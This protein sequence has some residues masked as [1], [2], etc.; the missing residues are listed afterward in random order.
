VKI[1]VKIGR[2]RQSEAQVEYQRQV[3]AAGGVYVIAKTFDGF[4]TW[5]DEF[6]K[7]E[8]ASHGK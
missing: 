8:E 7:V 5:Y 3:E 4:L 6:V 1:E 2:D